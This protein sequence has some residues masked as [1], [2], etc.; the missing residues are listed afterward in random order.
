MRVGPTTLA[1][2]SVPTP[3][4]DKEIAASERCL[5]VRLA[6]PRDRRAEQQESG[7]G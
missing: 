2:I 1:W 3:F 7:S 4:P 5:T 6:S